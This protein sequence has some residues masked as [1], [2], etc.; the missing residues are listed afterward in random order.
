MYPA[1]LNVVLDIGVDVE[2]SA[3]KFNILEMPFLGA[4]LVER[5]DTEARAVGNFRNG[6]QVVHLS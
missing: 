3:T 4:P 6:E 1:S 5:M 2:D